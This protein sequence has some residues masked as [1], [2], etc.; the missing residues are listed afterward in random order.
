[1]AITN[2]SRL[3]LA[4]KHGQ[5][6]VDKALWRQRKLKEQQ[7]FNESPVTGSSA[8]K[9]LAKILQK[10]ISAPVGPHLPLT[11]LEMDKLFQEKNLRLN[12]KVLGTSGSQLKDSLIVDKDVAKFLERDDIVRAVKLM[13]MARY[14][15]SFA[16]GTIV[17]Y[18]IK[19]GKINESFDLISKF[20]KRGLKLNGRVLNIMISDYSDA[21]ADK[22]V[23][24]S[25][26]K[27]VKLLKLVQG[28][29]SKGN[30]EIS[31]IHVNSLMKL[32]RK[33]RHPQ[34]SYH[35]YKFVKDRKSIKPDVRTYTELFRSL[36][37]IIPNQEI[38]YK[39]IIE[40]TERAFFAVQ[41]QLRIDID[42][43]MMYA[44]VNIFAH[45]Q[46]PELQ[47]RAI[48][49]IREWWRLCP[50]EEINQRVDY[51][52]VDKE[53][54]PKTFSEDKPILLD[55]KYINAKKTLRFVPDEKVLTL[56]GSLCDKFSL[57][58]VYKPRESKE[59]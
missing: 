41:H 5:K 7:N 8:E 53:E 34:L 44:Y 16:L 47:A 38:D 6:P 37:N 58:Y 19:T 17:R 21:I 35:F 52:K 59:V 24:K 29:I 1:M 11:A 55:W 9:L 32:F 2:K 14:Q 12:Y 54:G 22:T 45:S 20:K 39:D 26:M 43:S 31:K 23:E 18:L 28:E 57:D 56:Y 40:A 42:A 33:A 46:E 50:L 48:T 3:T 36:A 4:L 30:E 27:I 25:D 49:I 15:G 13:E 51:S 10:P